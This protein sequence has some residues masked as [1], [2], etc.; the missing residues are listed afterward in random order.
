MAGAGAHVGNA[1]VSVQPETKGFYKD[2]ERQLKEK[3]AGKKPKVKL[4]PEIDKDKWQSEIDRQAGED[5]KVRLKPDT[6]NLKRDL[7]GDLKDYKVTVGARLSSA[8]K[9]AVQ[10]ELKHLA[11]DQHATIHV[12]TD[13]SLIHI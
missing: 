12:R 2:L 10:A 3:F 7:R 11:D 8:D 6:D 9:A 5:M 1:W 4:D 13:L